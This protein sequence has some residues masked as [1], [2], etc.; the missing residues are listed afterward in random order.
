MRIAA[1]VKKRYYLSIDRRVADVPISEPELPGIKMKDDRLALAG[2]ATP[3]VRL[4]W[5]GTINDCLH[6]NWHE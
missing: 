6:N 1:D 3:Q 5:K 2:V 4:P